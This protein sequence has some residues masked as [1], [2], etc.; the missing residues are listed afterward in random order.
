MQTISGCLQWAQQTLTE[1][2]ALQGSAVVDS[3]WLLSHVL[4]RNSAWIKAWPDAQISEQHW[5][6]YQGLVRRR[7][8]GQP[9]SA[10]CRCPASIFGAGGPADQRLK[11]S[12]AGTGRKSRLGA[13]TRSTPREAANFRNSGNSARLGRIF[14]NSSTTS[15]FVSP[16]DLLRAHRSAILAVTR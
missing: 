4:Q 12:I 15:G 8:M 11:G 1:E 2:A 14:K 16:R 3:R 5:Q 7:A 13:L 9:V 6:Q 10:A